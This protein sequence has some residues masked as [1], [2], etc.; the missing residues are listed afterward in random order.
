VI[1]N[2]ANGATITGK[3]LDHPISGFGF[4]C[5]QIVFSELG[6]LLPRTFSDTATP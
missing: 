2:E 5:L 6:K 1:K 4:V 3:S